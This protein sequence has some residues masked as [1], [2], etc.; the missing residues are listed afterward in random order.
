MDP[1][2]S[3]VSMVDVSVRVVKYLKGIHADSKT[4]EID[5]QSL[6]HEVEA[7]GTV[8]NSIKSLRQDSIDKE[9][10]EFSAISELW[11]KISATIV[12]CEK[13][14]RSLDRT[15]KEIYGDTPEATGFKDGFAKVKR[16][17]SKEA[18]LSSYKE[19]LTSYHHVLDSLL[20]VIS[21]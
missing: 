17:R 1:V 12:D 9:E 14:L 15:I 21:L 3:A 13:I 19:S 6:I 10:T 16:M 7:I 2:A 8:T 20:K 5:I 18:Q 11:R 4:F